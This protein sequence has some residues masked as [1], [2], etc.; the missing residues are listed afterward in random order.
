MED[1][2][3]QMTFTILVALF[4]LCLGSFATAL[5]YR[6]PRQI[7]WISRGKN[8]ARSQCP[9]CSATLGILDLIPF[10]SWA[11]SR[12]KCRHCG[13]TISVLY[14][15]TELSAML[16]TLLLFYALGFTASSFVL[17][18]SIPF[19]V[20]A[21]VIDW[22]HFILPDDINIALFVLSILHVG[23]LLQEQGWNFEIAY[24]RLAAGVLLPLVFAAVSYCVG[25]WKKREALGMGDIKFLPSAGLLLGMAPV[26]TF[27]A[28]GGI[29]GL[30]TAFLKKKTASGEAFPFGPALIISLYIHLFLTGLG[31]DYKW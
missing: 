10:L 14:P 16:L 25:K 7:P 1:I 29:L 13:K 20:A 31:F 4:G 22:E 15:L 27:L 21:V 2:F 12:G 17:L 3:P 11:L 18:L 6:L 19:M 28:L 23:F 26:P 5:I 24:D 30:L 9:S 8:P